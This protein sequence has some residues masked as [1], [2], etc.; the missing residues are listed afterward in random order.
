MICAIQKIY[1]INCF[2]RVIMTNRLY[3]L[4]EARHLAE[5]QYPS[6][7]NDELFSSRLDQGESR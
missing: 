5:E 1:S 3:R 7:I 4:P 2:L 6:K